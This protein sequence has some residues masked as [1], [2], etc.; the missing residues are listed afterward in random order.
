MICFSSADLLILYF[1]LPFLS[2]I[3]PPWPRSVSV[4]RSDLL[5]ISKN[6]QTRS[7]CRRLAA[8]FDL[9]HP[10]IDSSGRDES[11]VKRSSPETSLCAATRRVC[12]RQT[13]RFRSLPPSPGCSDHLTI[14]TGLFVGTTASI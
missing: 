9:L 7:I 13:R 2:P 8:P 4:F 3:C 10:S 14:T 5:G 6:S 12:L 11:P 1:D